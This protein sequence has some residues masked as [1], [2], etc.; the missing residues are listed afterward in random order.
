MAISIDGNKT[1]DKIQHVFLIKILMYK[2]QLHWTMWKWNWEN[3]FIYNS[4]LR[5]KFKMVQYVQNIVE[6]N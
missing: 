2:D 5:Y 1:F 4:I 3:N 6:K